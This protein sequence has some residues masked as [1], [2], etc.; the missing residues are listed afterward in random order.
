M[1]PLINELLTGP[2][3]AELAPFIAA[4]NDDTIT[5]ILNRKDI[6]VY[7]TLSANDFAIWAASTGLRAVIEDHANNAQSPLRSIALTL[8]DL[9]KGNLE[10]SLDFGIPAN[11]T[12]LE[13]WVTAQA[14]TA[15]Q[16]DELLQMSKELIS[17]ADQ[18]GGVTLSQVSEALNN[19]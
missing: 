9:L 6:E 14:I 2:L 15:N 16:R 5:A 4:R 18:I 19:V 7:S 11:V 1:N 8:L 3:A 17:R 10:R 13:A 12:M